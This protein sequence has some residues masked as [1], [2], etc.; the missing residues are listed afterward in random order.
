MLTLLNEQ[1]QATDDF[2]SRPQCAAKTGEHNVA[3]SLTLVLGGARSGK[4]TWAERKARESGKSVL[5]VATATAGDG[6][7]AGRIAGHRASR[8]AEWRTV[9]AP[10]DLASAIRVHVQ[11]DDLVLVDCLTL[12]VSNL[13][14]RPCADSTTDEDLSPEAWSAIERDVVVATR[15]LMDAARDVD[16]SFIFISNEVGLGVVPAFPLG[17]YYRD[18]LGRVNQA[19]AAEAEPVILMIAGLP[20]DLRRLMAN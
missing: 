12:W 2:V 9:E 13:I 1:L 6:E 5:F 10:T 18:I 3:S 4:S 16:A 14:L 11:P 19:I 7:M 15:E 17:R 8:P 20:I